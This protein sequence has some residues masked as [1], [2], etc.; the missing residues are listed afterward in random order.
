MFKFVIYKVFVDKIII[1]MTLENIM[2]LRFIKSNM[3]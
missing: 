3:H 2:Y 1:S